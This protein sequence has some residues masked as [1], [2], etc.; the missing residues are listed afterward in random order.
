[1]AKTLIRLYDREDETS[2]VGKC[3]F[4]VLNGTFDELS[5]YDF[6]CILNSVARMSWQNYTNYAVATCDNIT[7]DEL[8]W[9]EIMNYNMYA[10]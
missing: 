3:Y 10:L 5:D 4:I 9:S 7:E 2:L 1:M 8:F 6:E